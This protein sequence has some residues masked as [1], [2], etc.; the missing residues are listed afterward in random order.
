MTDAAADVVVR[1]HAALDRRDLDAVMVLMHPD[2]RFENFL[3]GGELVGLVEVRAFYQRLFDTL[4]PGFDVLATEILPDGRVRIDMQ[5]A[6]HDRSGHLWS[7]SR[8][9]AVY[10]L[11]DGLVTGVVLER[12]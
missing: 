4:S 5:V 7:D 8:S 6:V 12:A 2:V 11:A 9:G 1:L 10:S 3:D